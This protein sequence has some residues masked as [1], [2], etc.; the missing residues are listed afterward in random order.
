MTPHRITRPVT[1]LAISV[2]AL[3]AGIASAQAPAFPSKPVRLVLPVPA[4]SGLDTISRV[5]SQRLS[6]IWGQPVVVE[7]RVGG[8]FIIG[9]EN[10][11]RSAPDGH[12]LLVAPDAALTVN[13]HLYAKLP[14]DPVRD[15]APVVQLVTFTQMMVAAPSLPA[16][17]IA[18]LA[19][20]SSA[21]PGKV[22]YAS[23]GVGSQ[24]H[25]LSELVKVRTGAD[26]LHVPYKGI[27][28][29]ITAVLAGET[30]LTWSSPFSVS[31]HVRAGRLK[32]LALAAAKRT[33][34]MPDVPTFAEL[35]WPDIDYVMWFG[36]LAP[37][38]TPRAIVNRIHADFV[39]VISDPDVRDKELLA[40]GYDPSGMGPEP[41]GALIRREIGLRGEMVK[42][43]GAKAE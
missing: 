34:L 29:A 27:P 13:P 26:L 28:Q 4:G 21:N 2:M 11:A 35:G 20:Y 32:A 16:N 6:P 36:I 19:A 43:T 39:K 18:E 10:V 17:T 5:F 12:S 30:Q 23:F 8:N 1:A 3:C 15:F 24:P 33:S 25:L 9:S 31:G 42:R 37:A 22:S 14:Y 40:K 7:N 38:G 41:F